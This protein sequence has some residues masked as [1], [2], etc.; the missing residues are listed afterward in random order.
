MSSFLG[1]TYRAEK[2]PVYVVASSSVAALAYFGL[3]NNFS[4]N[5]NVRVSS[6]FAQLA[7]EV[8]INLREALC[9]GRPASLWWAGKGDST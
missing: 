9:D 7:S 4:P 1:Q 8:R 6:R 5:N 2:W 3:A